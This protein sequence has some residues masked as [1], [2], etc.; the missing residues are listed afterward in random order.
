MI[1]RLAAI[2]AC[3]SV[4]IVLAQQNVQHV[5]MNTLPK[6][7]FVKV[8]RFL[9]QIAKNVHLKKFVQHVLRQNMLSIPKKH[10]LFAPFSSKTA[11]N[12]TTLILAIPA[13]VGSN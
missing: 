2:N 7:E 8:V 5:L 6:M 3:K 10:A 9:L 13:Q 11:N 4:W 1:T 12:A